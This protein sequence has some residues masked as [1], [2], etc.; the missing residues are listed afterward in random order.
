MSLYLP[1]ALRQQLI[2]ADDHRCAYCHTFQVNSGYPMVV[3]HVLPRSKG[4]TETFE[5]LCYACHRCTLFKH[6]TTKLQDPITRIVTP[7]FHPRQHSWSDHFTWANDGIHLIGNTAI[8]RV[9]IISLNVNNDA[10][11]DARLNWL[12]VGWH[13]PSEDKR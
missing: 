13:P 5:N 7:L 6:T 1:A 11:L 9:T 8:G 12:R 2:E 3:D 10:I 4:G